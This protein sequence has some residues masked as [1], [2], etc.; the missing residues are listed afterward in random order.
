M[1]T[2]GASYGPGF[3]PLGIT[4]IVRPDSMRNRIERWIQEL[5]PEP[6]RSMPRS[7]GTTFRYHVAL[8]VTHRAL[9]YATRLSELIQLR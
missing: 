3:T 8:L 4:H 6:I 9:R 1:V 7:P 5:K 2:D